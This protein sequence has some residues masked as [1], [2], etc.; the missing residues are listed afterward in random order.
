VYGDFELSIQ[1]LRNAIRDILILEGGI[2]RFAYPKGYTPNR[3]YKSSDEINFGSWQGVKVYKGKD[4]GVLVLK[5]NLDDGDSTKSWDSAVKLGAKPVPDDYLKKGSN[6]ELDLRKDANS[7]E[8]IARNFQIARAKSNSDIKKTAPFNGSNSFYVVVDSNNI[9]LRD[10]KAIESQKEFAENTM[11]GLMLN[12]PLRGYGKLVHSLPPQEQKYFIKALSDVASAS[13]LIAGGAGLGGLVFS[14]VPGL[15]VAKGAASAASIGPF[16][17]LSSIA[18]DDGDP[19]IAAGNLLAA[20]TFGWDALGGL[21]TAYASAV[22]SAKLAKTASQA[23]R[24]AASQLFATSELSGL[25]RLAEKLFNIPGR[26]LGQVDNF[27]KFIKGTSSLLT[28]TVWKGAKQGWTLMKS[29]VPILDNSG[30]AII[31][32]SE[33]KFFLEM[34]GNAATVAIADNLS[35]IWES[36]KSVVRF[37]FPIAAETAGITFDILQLAEKS[38]DVSTSKLD[39]KPTEEQVQQMTRTAAANL[40]ALIRREAG[41]KDHTDFYRKMVGDVGIE[42]TTR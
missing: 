23:S 11:L 19:W 35:K 39:D 29:G 21:T 25:E 42:P 15:Q 32:T 3:K 4:D 10:S 22:E 40:R 30:N 20:A 33:E 18:L 9:N 7:D 41:S 28:G 27:I 1:E 17:A 36:I 37:A 6:F 31:F 24:S 16:L 38:Q 26:L 12:N 14:G 2:E 34:V 13:S 5:L 8:A